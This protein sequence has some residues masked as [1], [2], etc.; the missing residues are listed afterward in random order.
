MQ[1]DKKESE[2]NCRCF[3]E[4]SANDANQK[5]RTLQNFSVWQGRTLRSQLML[6]QLPETSAMWKRWM[7]LWLLLSIL[8]A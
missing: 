5:E 2:N 3:Y 1:A 7:P 8:G 6:R 4:N